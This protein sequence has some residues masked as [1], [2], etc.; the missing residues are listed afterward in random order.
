MYLAIYI[1]VRVVQEIMKSSQGQSH[2]LDTYIL[3]TKLSL[4]TTLIKEKITI[5]IVSVI[6]KIDS[7]SKGDEPSKLNNIHLRKSSN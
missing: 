1:W 3:N 7:L 2:V 6:I 4:H 5:C